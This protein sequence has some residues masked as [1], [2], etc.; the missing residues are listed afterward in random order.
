MFLE[1]AHLVRAFGEFGAVLA[2]D[3]A[4]I[5]DDVTALLLL[6]TELGECVNHDTEHDI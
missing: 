5:V 2:T 4:R 6:L 3:K 1:E